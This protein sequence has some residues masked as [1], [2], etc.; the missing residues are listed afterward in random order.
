MFGS[1]IAQPTARRLAWV[2]PPRTSAMAG[3]SGI[4][5]H[6][7]VRLRAADDPSCP[8]TDPHPAKG[9]V[10]KPPFERAP[11]FVNPPRRAIRKTHLKVS[12]QGESASTLSPPLLTLP[13]EGH[14]A[15]DPVLP[16]D[17]SARV[18]M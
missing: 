8:I 7:P 15:R 6:L 3:R 13:V 14:C 17:G 18:Q 9:I 16:F 2:E 12:L 5:A 11:S 4:G 1:G 10:G